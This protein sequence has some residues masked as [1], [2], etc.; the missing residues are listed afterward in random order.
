MFRLLG[1][2]AVVAVAALVLLVALP[3]GARELPPPSEGLKTPVRGVIHVHTNRSDGTAPVDEVLRAAA[4]A[5]LQFVIVTDHGDATRAPDLPDYRNGVLYID[6]VEISTGNGHV[7][8][9]GLPKAPYPL[10]GEGRDVVED[11]H[12][13]GGIAIAAHPGSPKPELGWTDWDV[14]LDGIEWLNADS[15]WRDERAWTL[16]R[17]LLTYPFR[18]PQAL[19]LLLDRPEPVLRQWDA[20]TEQR[21]VSAVAASDAHAR[22]GV[23]SLGEP[24]DSAGSLH[25]PAYANSFREFS[26]AL[27]DTT[28]TGAADAD[29]RRVIDAIR[30]GHV[31]STVDALGGPAALRF[32]ATSGST[33]AAMGDALPLAGPVHLHVDAQAPE[34]ATIT[35][36]R[37]GAAATTSRGSRLDHDA[38]EAAGVYRVEI[39]LPDAPGSPPVPW[40]LGNP[41]YVGREVEKPVNT[42]RPAPRNFMTLYDGGP[43]RG[44][45]IEKTTASDG[46][47]DVIGALGGTQLLLR[48][49]ISGSAEENPYVG[50]V[51]P[52][53]AA[54]AMYERLVFSA[55]ADR[56][57]RLSVQLR[58]PGGE[59]ERWR[60]SV[61][62]D[63]TPRTVDLAFND[64][65][66]VGSTS[67]AQPELTKID[68]I[69]FVV[70]TINNK[71]GSNGQ[72]QVDDIQYAR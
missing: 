9:L 12:R 11:I 31:Y 34:D 32:V 70:D 24:Y 17:A 20:L 53:T 41:V 8:A 1:R 6:A 50:F 40:L 71:A 10:A 29:A 7:V 64:F 5:G 58:S 48:F 54:I 63:S 60:R 44:W 66:P 28:L 56:P 43:T 65:R 21:R 39:G 2:L 38:P 13:L 35:L 59:G 68:S 25:F 47:M 69:L 57:M 49:A 55:R 22:V 62:L 72:I 61:Y 36:F 26:V 14:P 46:A 19:A 33:T 45:R 16:A 42:P 15:E 51:M 37:D 23:R 18:P 67:T 52:A 4:R 30:D 27:S 3:R